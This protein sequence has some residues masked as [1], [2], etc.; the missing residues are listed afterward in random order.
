MSEKNWLVL[1][2]Q[3]GIKSVRYLVLSDK[4]QHTL[5]VHEVILWKKDGYAQSEAESLVNA[6]RD[7]PMDLQFETAKKMEG[8]PIEIKG[9]KK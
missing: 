7:L 3:N 9:G 4:D 5:A 6:F 1:C 8:Q 2:I